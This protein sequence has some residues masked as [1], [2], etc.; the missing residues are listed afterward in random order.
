MSTRNFYKLIIK[1]NFILAFLILFSPGCN[2][3]FLVENP[4]NSISEGIFW[5]TEGEAF[6]ALMGVY[7]NYQERWAERL[8][9]LDKSMIWMSAYAGY[10]SWRSF[11][12]SRD[13][14]I[15]PTHGTVTTMWL[16]MF[17]QVS[18]CNYF[19]DNIDKVE[20]DA[21]KKAQMAAEVRF[22][23][24]FS[25]FWLSQ[26]Y[27]NV[28]LIT[29]TLTFEEANTATQSTEAQIVDF[30]V[31]ELTEIAPALPVRQ[32]SSDIGRIERGAALALK[33]R[34]LMAQKKWSEAASTYKAIMDLNRYEIDPRYKKL[35]EDEGENNDEYIFAN[36]Y[37]EN[38]YGEAMSQ[39]TI[40]C[41]LYGGYNACNVF[42][43]FVDAFP[44]NDGLPIDESPL[45]DPA[46]PYE[47][48]DPRLYA[49]LLLTGYT[50]VY[51]PDKPEG[52]VFQGD[53]ATIAKSGQTG[54][55]ISGY[56]LQK[57]W[58]PMYEGNRQYYGGD[59]PQIRYA[60]V[61]LSY[62]E[63][64][65]EAGDAIDQ[66]LLDQTINMVRQREDIDMPPVTETNPANLREIL[67]NERWIE[68]AFEGGVRYFDIR[69][70]GILVE[71]VNRQILG[72]KITDDPANYDGQYNVNEDGYLILG[73]LKC[74]NHNYL[75]PIPLTELDVN[76]NMVQNPGYN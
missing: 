30:I 41:S 34:C 2:E 23:R 27:G 24:A 64:K 62:L 39:H 9:N 31:A 6:Q 63:S 3:D 70:W 16:K 72:L 71:E 53:P 11:A 18:R 26:T 52:V 58:D 14:E 45:F 69:R 49:T 15:L 4:T 66:A 55:N 33:G 13:V 54:P 29:T 36:Q 73:E 43:H 12:W 37:M 60:E 10:A 76:D 42:Q 68:L 67:R 51:L 8:N 7:Y 38:E 5:Q 47:N 75:W 21:A 28:P 25:Y 35:F 22:L 1:V 32:P 46:N 74:Y 50:V 44:M 65:L 20:M 40:R 57:Y 59:Y 48:R 61:L 56:M 19:L 17:R